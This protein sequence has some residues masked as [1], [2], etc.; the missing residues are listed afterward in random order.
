[1]QENEKQAIH[2]LT[3]YR[4]FHLLLA[5]T[6][7]VYAVS[8]IFSERLK[9]SQDAVLIIINLFII[10]LGIILIITTAWYAHK[11]QNFLLKRVEKFLNTDEDQIKSIGKVKYVGV[12]FVLSIVVAAIYF[13]GATVRFNGSGL[14]A[15]ILFFF[16]TINLQKGL[17]AKI[18][19][20]EE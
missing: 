16:M 18:E 2:S 8:L 5:F 4:H 7:A 11:N 1:M 20:F 10:L 19:D 3:V 14:M 12:A 15:A 17:T 13:I 6:E 9:S